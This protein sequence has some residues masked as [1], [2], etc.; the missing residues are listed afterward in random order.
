MAPQAAKK[1]ARTTGIGQFQWLFVVAGKG[2]ATTRGYPLKPGSL[3]VIEA[4]DYHDS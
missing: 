2:E 3:L 1:E 4:G